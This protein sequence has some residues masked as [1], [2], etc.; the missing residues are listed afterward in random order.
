[1]QKEQLK[2]QDRILLLE[3][4]QDILKFD[5]KDREII[6]S[7][8]L[9]K[10]NLKKKKKYFLSWKQINEMRDIISFGSHT[11]SHSILSTLNNNDLENELKKSKN[12]L[13]K[14][15]K[16]YTDVIA[17]PWGLFNNNVINNVKKYYKA[18]LTTIPGFVKK[19]LYKLKRIPAYNNG[20]YIFASY[21]ELF[22]L[23]KLYK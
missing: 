7:N 20:K 11:H 14:K 21:I 2:I 4:L 1:M 9:K 8:L 6:I 23:R 5:V 15:I 16:S 19:D 13:I 12:I 18:G 22:F 3:K 10:F 17:Y